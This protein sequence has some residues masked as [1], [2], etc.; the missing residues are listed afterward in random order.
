MA[1]VPGKTKALASAAPD[2]FTQQFLRPLHDNPGKIP[3]GNTRHRG[4][5]KA[6]KDILYVTGIEARCPNLNKN[7]PGYRYR[8]GHVA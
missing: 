1:A 3:T 8:P 6:P 5:G 7:F 2:R 4:V